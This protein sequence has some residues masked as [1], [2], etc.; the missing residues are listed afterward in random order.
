VFLGD[1]LAS[2]L[3]AIEKGENLKATDA[4]IIVLGFPLYLYLTRII[5]LTG[6]RTSPFAFTG[7]NLSSGRLVHLN[8]SS[9]PATVLN[10]IVAESIDE[11]TD[12]IETAGTTDIR[13]TILML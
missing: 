7:I 8:R 11:L 13:K 9:F 6:T 2:I 4:A 1:Q 3:E 10:L 12:K 5:I